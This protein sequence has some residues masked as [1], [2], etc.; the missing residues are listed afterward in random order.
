[1]EN[2]IEENVQTLLAMGF[3]D[4]DN[5][6]RALELGKNDLNEAV[7]YLTCEMPMSSCDSTNDVNMDEQKDEGPVLYP[8]PPPSYEA[9][10]TN[11]DE[12]QCA[13]EGQMEFPYEHLVELEGRVFTESW[14]I[15]FRKDESLAKCLIAATKLFNEGLPNADENCNRFLDKCMPECFNKLLTSS[16]VQRW[17]A[18]VQDGIYDMLVLFI[19]LI[20]T[21][22]K[23]DP[24]PLSML[25][26]L[27]MAFDPSC[28]WNSKN[29]FRTWPQSLW[30]S[31]LG[32]LDKCFARPP[33]DEKRTIRFMEQRGWM[34]SLINIFCEK[35]GLSEIEAVLERSTS[36]DASQY[37]A[38]LQPFSVC[39]DWLN[40]DRV[41]SS[42]APV[43]E[44]AVTYVR[45]LSE[46]DFK[47]K[48]LSSLSE[49]LN[50][51]KGVCRVMWS[52][53]VSFVDDL[54][55]EVTL[56]MMKCPH[57][58]AKM[59]ALKE[60]VKLIE[61]S[62]SYLMKDS[63]IDKEKILEWLVEN[64]V[65]SI[66]LDGHI[67]QSQYCDK[68]K[69]V[70]EFIG[71]K[72][73][74][75]ELAQLWKL[76]NNASLSVSENIQSIISG[77]A[78][79]FNEQQLDLL[80]SLIHKSW[81]S[82]DERAR[83]Q[84]VSFIGKIGHNAKLGKDMEKVLNLLWDLA[85]HPKLS[86]TLVDMLLSEHNAIL[87]ESYLIKDAVKKSFIM[88]CIED[89]RKDQWIVPSLKQ[90]C[91]ISK[92]IVKS[93]NKLIK[94]ERGFLHELNKTNEIVKLVAA[95]LTR[96]HQMAAT[97]AKTQETEL[98]A[99]M[100]VSDRYKHSDYMWH[101]LSLLKFL[102]KEGDL[103]LS[104]N[105]AKDIWDTLIANREA[106]CEDREACCDWFICILSDLE[107]EA[108]KL[109]F[110]DRLL[111]CDINQMSP[112]LFNC[113]IAFLESANVLEQKIKRPHGSVIVD[114]L[115]L[116]GIDVL[117]RICLECRCL[118]V[119]NKAISSLV[120]YAYTDVSYKLKKDVVTLHSKFLNECYKR[121]NSC[122]NGD[123]VG[124]IAKAV[125][126][127]TKTLAANIL[128]DSAVASSPGK[129]NKY[130]TIE[131]LLKIVHQYISDIE[132]SHTDTRFILPHGE[133]FRGM[134]IILKVNYESNLQEFQ[135]CT[136]GNDTVRSLRHR[137]AEEI[138]A[139]TDHVQI[140]I[141]ERVIPFANDRLLL[142][143]CGFSENQL[144]YVKTISTVSAMQIDEDPPS[145]NALM[146]MEQKLP[147]VVLSNLG[148][149][150]Y[151]VLFQLTDLDQPQITNYVRKLLLL[152]PT[153]PRI[154][155]S[156]EC[157]DIGANASVE[158][159]S[160]SSP[161]SERM[162]GVPINGG[163]K[164]KERSFE[165]I[166][167]VSS[168]GMNLFR[169]RYNLEVLSGLLMP[170]SNEQQQASMEDSDSFMR[171]FMQ[172]G[173]LQTV[174]NI[175]QHEIVSESIEQI[176][177][178][179]TRTG[180]Y[181]IV[182]SIAR[183]L[184]CVASSSENISQHDSNYSNNRFS[185]G[186]EAAVSPMKRGDPFRVGSFDAS[187]TPTKR[188]RKSISGSPVVISCELPHAARSAVQVMNSDEFTS[189]I[190]TLVRVAWFASAAKLD[191][192]T[193]NQDLT[194]EGTAFLKGRRCSRESVTSTAM[195]PF[196]HASTS[197]MSSTGSVEMMEPSY[198][199]N[200]DTFTN[201][202]AD[203]LIARQTL[204]LLV[205]CLKLR[206]SHLECF[207]E[208]SC[209][210]E[211]IIDI[212]T[213]PSDIDLRD[214]AVE[215]FYELSNISS[216]M[217]KSPRQQLLQ[218]LVKARVPF[219]H[220]TTL[221]RSKAQSLVRNCLQYFTLRCKLLKDVIRE[222]QQ[223]HCGV[224]EV[225]SLNDELSWL[226]DF[227]IPT[228]THYAESSAAR[229]LDN[230]LLTGHLQ[231]IKILVSSPKVNKKEIGL[232]LIGRLLSE[233]LFP[234]S[235]LILDG[236][237]QS[238]S[239]Q[240]IANFQPKCSS[241]DSRRAAFEVLIELCKECTENLSQVSTQLIS[242]HH[243]HDQSRAKEFDFAPLVVERPEHGFVGLKNG[244][245]TCYMNSVLQQFFMISDIT[246]AVLS[247]DIES[248]TAQ[249]E[250]IFYQLQKV[251]AHLHHSRLQY[252][253]P[254][255]FWKT[256]KLWG[257]G[258]NIR[259]Q[260][261]AFEFLTN[262]TD[263]ID[264]YLKSK[265]HRG[266][267]GEVFR[268]L[269]SDQKI[270]EGCPH[271]YEREEPYFALNLPVKSGSLEDSLRQFVA[272]EKLEGDN[273][274]LCEK[275]N[276]KRTVLKRTCI[277]TLPPV[278][279][280]QLKR[281]GYDWE[282][283][284]SLKFD[285][286]FRFPHEVDMQPYLYDASPAHRTRHRTSEQQLY[287]LVGIVIHSGQAQAGHYYSLIKDRRGNPTSN[288]HHGRWFKFNDTNVEEFE[289]T[290]Q[291]LEE[292]CFGGTFTSKVYERG[293]PYDEER[294]RYWN[295][296]LLFYE[297]VPEIQ[298]NRKG[299][300]SFM[301]QT[302]IINSGF[303]SPE[304]S[305]PNSPRHANDIRLSQLTNLIRKGEQHGIFTSQIPASIMQLVGEENL[306]FMRNRG[307]YSRSYFNFIKSLVRV[308]LHCAG[309]YPAIAVTSLQLAT[310]FLFRTY[311]RTKR[312]MLTEC[313]E[314]QAI[315]VALFAV[316]S[317]ACV[318]F[319]SRLQSPT[320]MANVVSFLLE[321]PNELVRNCFTKMLGKALRCM[322]TPSIT[323]E[324]RAGVLDPM[325]SS[326]LSLLDREVPER[327]RRSN[328]FFTLSA[329]FTATDGAACTALL[330]H[331]GFARLMKFLLGDVPTKSLFAD[332]IPPQDGSG[333]APNGD[334]DDEA[335][336]RRWSSA[337]SREFLSLHSAIAHVILH[338]DLS[339]F[340]SAT[341]K[342]G[343]YPPPIPRTV[344]I[345]NKIDL[346]PS[347][348]LALSGS[349]AKRYL[350]E[351][352][353]AAREIS[354]SIALVND[355]I[356]HCC[357]NNADF[358]SL[359]IELL[360]NEI[361]SV[362]SNELKPLLTIL[363]ELLSVP[364]SLHR[365]R[366]KDALERPTKGF[367]DVIKETQRSDEAKSYQCVKALVQLASRSEPTR[368]YLLEISSSW[369]CSVT[370][371]KKKMSE[372]SWTSQSTRS[373]DSTTSKYFQRTMSA[374]HT[375]DEAT[376]LLAAT[377]PNPNHIED[378][379]LPSV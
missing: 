304:I 8:A 339:K 353:F 92:T 191:Q 168:P 371:L 296:Y 271:R 360:S 318:W 252:H 208:L 179:N 334:V 3:F 31:K 10:I 227:E 22:L 36:L 219:W 279:T 368:Q 232:Q 263:Q 359:V 210:G 148:N 297:K 299:R 101:H 363:V 379:D 231:L 163:N 104:W 312:S 294:L 79:Q 165:T 58:N 19:D 266:I 108:V 344:T 244:G 155:R 278:L 340:Q 243:Y 255:T 307:I 247:T 203:L 113:F 242:M 64:T 212:L 358:S 250:T 90:L 75:D 17:P 73:N 213:R 335:I 236:A 283:G 176:G 290:E 309:S 197:S 326:L 33:D 180:C 280:I 301:K 245:A 62:E 321:C 188:N 125:N 25:N 215:Q 21:R 281:F 310:M 53:D 78:P 274:Y 292:E 314:W 7:S 291:S 364:D 253:E 282:A 9:A 196:R 139:S 131:R 230:R 190:F 56:R 315:V 319:I 223:K 1:M 251:F 347:V 152:L 320:G 107:N 365:T 128:P 270:C 106:C 60:V 167:R 235:K 333:D 157:T 311:F 288:P 127:A 289:M 361:V 87:G 126:I 202:N 99:N 26:L 377:Q 295:A 146:E 118:D 228:S 264:E 233:F 356:L 102:L 221:L 84:L 32:G 254:T 59:N 93:H 55:L 273:A 302:Q 16:A 98:S 224:D 124:T 143:E 48:K 277:K 285:H 82:E 328:Q 366:L 85:H 153:D 144:V 91:E 241:E 14:S 330:R 226:S 341:D 355:V 34:V 177:D 119:A 370:W 111:R 313:D 269:F 192:I 246:Q 237:V 369:S 327:V 337:Q 40:C 161:R 18:D 122:Q 373:N 175:L 2:T 357:H 123:N 173:G 287:R 6:Q 83:R 323:K 205:L 286:Y 222:N 345:N 105:R 142:H 164:R 65:L 338:T 114:K 132:Y 240:S 74:S 201:Q 325:I 260:Q 52:D 276:E 362:A 121:L 272:G 43:I 37:A 194:V 39:V 135:I 239:Q 130:L 348:E 100:L 67:D 374:Q 225:Q 293:I 257:K 47:L 209:I 150:V 183:F 376:A 15:P 351:L 86:P 46:N 51:M 96:C 343:E 216:A 303:S 72:L 38:L 116:V 199:V 50:A 217:S 211:F 35:G 12:V 145:K 198:V 354:T 70:V 342:N 350:R 61:E 265:E 162:D 186:S 103:Y 305:P 218:I 49:L 137:I 5:V 95:S 30:V 88:K 11:S 20:V 149:R 234:A 27:G 110:R 204:E 151:D 336:S 80:F 229:S 378:E 261:D 267:F 324:Q 349:V 66:S 89:I 109:I 187:A 23:Y 346:S 120:R 45:E 112:C 317:P 238:H 172:N 171:M 258:V 259:E 372:H 97:S 24:L 248:E 63:A 275:C 13:D 159:D 28:A 81:S 331:N 76:Q 298:P 158:D 77:A 54:R 129:V 41:Q 71:D 262:L 352:L 140:I 185:V 249:E 322:V 206:P 214:C 189:L 44:R 195:S 284:R 300:V 138:D 154:R 133:F 200:Q 193:S 169:L 332:S 181:A 178:A 184:L 306:Q 207:F 166:F 367:V 174:L 57:F 147:S 115:E 182:L 4:R 170:V 134:L 136:H 308:N 29:K 268:G 69:K 256:F 375:L 94:S 160:S 42:I 141:N 117:W 156:I 68:I 220:Q 316:S 329:E